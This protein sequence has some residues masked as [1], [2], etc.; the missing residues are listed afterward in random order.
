MN[1]TDGLRRPLP[2]VLVATVSTALLVLLM[3]PFRN[4]IGLL[5]AG[6]AFLLLTLLIASYWGREV[7]LYAAVLTNLAF[8]FFFI[9][10]LHR[11]SVQEPSNVGALFVF[12]AVSVVGGTLL[13]ATRQAAAQARLRQAEAETVLAL[14]R[15]MSSQT[16]PD[17]AL[18]VLCAHVTTAFAAAG[19]AV[20]TRVDNAWGVLAHAGQVAAAR[21]PTQEERVLAERAASESAVQGLGSSGFDTSRVRRI[22]IPAGRSAAF[23][24][25]RS[26]I[27][28]PL[29]LGDRVLGVLRLDG[30][31]G[32]SPFKAN[33]AALLNAVAS[34]AAITLQRI[35]LAREAAH[36]EALREADEMKTALMA[37]IS[38]D[39]KTPLAGIKAAITSI[40]DK[41]ISWAESDLDAFHHTIDSQADRLNR[42]IS[43]IL[44]LNRIESGDLT[45]EQ[46]PLLVL[47]LLNRAREATSYETQGRKV[48]VAAQQSLRVLT[49]ESLVTQALVNLIENAAKYSTPGAAIHLS[50]SQAG[51]S[52]LLVVE[53]EG[54]GIAPQDLP[55]VFERFYRAEEHSR[56]VKGSG[57]GLTIVKGFVELCGGTV[58]VE[59]LAERTRFTI[60][61]PAVREGVA[62]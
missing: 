14:S 22:V 46:S 47:D 40:L 44:D 42:V 31:V 15:A 18:R 27:M 20:L 19:A 41:R 52:A 23:S 34:E 43:D 36:A 55:Y 11:L 53:D 50:A 39:L 28:A 21:T 12:L 3:S 37:S 35:E 57:L 30:P 25:E 48:T 29:Q 58:A 26:V 10:P 51:D 49:D 6:F 59:S 9:E 60:K 1:T 38:H 7:G 8:N 32:D 2:G 5:N 4:D 61:L 24:R 33:P 62:V 45:P 13:S 54:P 17:E 56:R 16:E